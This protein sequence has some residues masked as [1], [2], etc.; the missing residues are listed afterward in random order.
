[1]ILEQ[2]AKG[3]SWESVDWVDGLGFVHGLILIEVE[4]RRRIEKE[5]KRKT[6]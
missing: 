4:G 2:T 5:S 1:M 3:L 6:G